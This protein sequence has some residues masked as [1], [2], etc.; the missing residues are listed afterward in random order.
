MDSGRFEKRATVMRRPVIEDA[1]GEDTGQRG[2]YA[3]AMTL[4]ANYRPLSAREAAQ[5][6]RA[7]N[8]ETGTLTIRDSAQARTVSNADRI[9]LQ[10]KDF[11]ITGVGLPDRR[12]GTIQLNISTD[13]GGE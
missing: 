9:A 1:D 3:P 11:G 4:W 12:T 8:V 5:G 7:Q 13:L 6:G 2:D 10:G